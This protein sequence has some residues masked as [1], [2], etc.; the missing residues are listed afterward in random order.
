MTEDVVTA[1]RLELE[2]ITFAEREEYA[3]AIE[4]F[5]A[6]IKISP[7]RASGYNNRAQT[8]RLMGRIEG[9]LINCNYRQ[10][11]HS[12]R[13][14]L[15]ITKLV[16]EAREDLNNA[17]NLS[18]GRGRAACQAYCQRGLINLKENRTED[19]K[20]DFEFAVKLGSQFAKA[21]LVQLNPYAALCNK[22]LR[23]VFDKLQKGLPTTDSGEDV[24]AMKQ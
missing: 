13:I 14:F 18:Q 23:G 12:C 8:L 22:M 19:A 11:E 4:L 3:R 16:T 7:H 17:I 10:K 2:G 24:I 9:E 21:Q 15:L 1:K 6:S 20:R 5:S